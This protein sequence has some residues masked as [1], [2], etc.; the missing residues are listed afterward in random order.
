M[1]K[2]YTKCC[3]ETSSRPFCEKLKLAISLD[4]WSK[5]LQSLVFIVWQVEGYRNKL[6]YRPLAFTSY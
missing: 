2:L 6:S 3:G 5:V 4:Q 1:K